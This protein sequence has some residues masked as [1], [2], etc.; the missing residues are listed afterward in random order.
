MPTISS[1]SV[2][3]SRAFA[4][5]VAEDRGEL[6]QHARRR[7]RRLVRELRDGAER[8]EEE[9]RLELRLEIVEP[10]ARRAT[11]RED[12]PAAGAARARAEA[13]AAPHT[14]TIDEV[15]DDVEV[16][17]EHDQRRRRTTPAASA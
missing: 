9:V 11:A 6:A 8:I 5:R 15:R 17:V 13:G 12:R 16:E 10:R 3:S 1:P 14:A 4:E 7:R 2:I